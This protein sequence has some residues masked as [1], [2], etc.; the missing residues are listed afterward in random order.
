MIE[1]HDHGIKSEI[2][3]GVLSEMKGHDDHDH[4]EIIYIGVLILL[5]FLF[6]FIAEKVAS[7]HVHSHPH[8]Q[9][10]EIEE[11]SPEE[12][13]EVKLKETVPDSTS[14]G[15]R[16]RVIST[17]TIHNSS[18]L[19]LDD[20]GART[21]SAKNSTEG[22]GCFFP[23]FSKLSPSGWLN[24]LADSM[25]NFTDGIALGKSGS[26]SSTRTQSVFIPCKLIFPYLFIDLSMF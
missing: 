6:F 21:I 4:F 14:G 23:S 13:K 15:L 26:L 12:T 9:L 8:E 3:V 5:G 16:R 18:T 1:D 25:H 10:S 20:D 22:I 19:N 24:L 11:Y 2:V 7:R 17:S